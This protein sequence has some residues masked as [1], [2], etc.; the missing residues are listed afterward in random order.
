MKDEKINFI[1]I[2]FYLIATNLFGQNLYDINNITQ[3]NIM[4]EQANWDYL[5]DSLYAAGNE[6]RLVGSVDI[7]GIEFEQVGVRYKGNSSYNVNNSKNPFNIKLDHVI[8]EQTYNGFGTLKLANGFKYPS[9]V[10]ETLSYEIAWN[11]MPAS[12]ANYAKVIVNDELIGLYTS[13][14]DVDKFFKG[15]HYPANQDIRFKGELSGSGS[16]NSPVWN[17][18]DDNPASYYDYF[19]IESDEGWAELINFLDI[20]NNEPEQIEDVL[21]IDIHLW[22][23]AFDI[24]MVNLDA[25]VNFGHNYYLFS[26]YNQRFSPIL[27]DLNEN[28]GGFINLNSSPP[29][30]LYQLQHLNPLLNYN[31]SD[32]PIIS[33]VLTNAT[34]RRMYLA[35]MRTIIEEMF[36]SGYYEARALELQDIIATEYQADPNTFYSYEEFLENI[37]STVGGTCPGNIPICGITELMETRINWLLEHQ[38]FQGTIPEILNPDYSP[39]NIESNMTVTI[40]VEVTGADEVYLFYRT[41]DYTKFEKIEMLDDGLHNDEIANDGIF[42]ISIESGYDDIQYYFYAQNTQQGKFKPQHASQEFYEIEINNDANGIVINEINYNSSDEFDPSDW[43][44]FFNI[45]EVEIDLSGW[46]FKDEEDDHIFIFPENTIIDTNDYLVLCKDAEQFA[47]LF[48]EVN[49]YLGE[50]DFGFSGGGEL[51]RLFNAESVLIDSVEYDDDEPWP[52]APDGDGS[53]LELISP[54]LDNSLIENWIASENHGTPGFENS[55][56]SEIDSNLINKK[57]ISLSNYSNPFNSITNIAF[58]LV[59]QRHIKLEVY[60]LKGQLVKTLLNTVNESGNHSVI[61]NGKDK[62]N[63]SVS[64]GIYLYRIQ[65]DTFSISKKMLLLK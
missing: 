51:L 42:G 59:E 58:S 54:E 7:N 33:N 48:P 52:E 27:W 19:K 8:E 20:L 40:K 23:L 46:V 43:I 64:S 28:F 53:T 57:N 9:F 29:L 11:Y 56:I 38:E 16:M 15:N 5:L 22:M 13:V 41:G 45:D 4:F 2:L 31:D 39:V 1:I 60:N 14:Q 21:N 17:Y 44:E 12:H 62:Y 49:N 34:Y 65:A 6:E 32:Y 10:R 3:I 50:I 37:N 26:D 35:H 24:L 36:Q 63:K 61:W 47:N 30:D 25:P 55:S 18:Y